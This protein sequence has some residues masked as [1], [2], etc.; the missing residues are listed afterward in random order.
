MDVSFTKLKPNAK[1]GDYYKE[2]SEMLFKCSVSHQS[3]INRIQADERSPLGYKGT[4]EDIAS[5]VS[6]IA[7]QESH[8][9]TGQSVSLCA[10]L[11]DISE[12]MSCKDIG[13]WRDSFRL[14]ASHLC[15]VKCMVWVYELIINVRND[16]FS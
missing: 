3:I 5:I 1:E 10:M 8:F 12:L 9:I 7:S 6:Y 15:E 13:Q 2:A 11:N 4:P 16:V 14:N